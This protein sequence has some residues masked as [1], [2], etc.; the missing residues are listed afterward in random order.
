MRLNLLVTPRCWQHLTV[1]VCNNKQESLMQLQRLFSH[2]SVQNCFNLATFVRFSGTNNLR[3]CHNNSIGF[4]SELWIGHLDIILHDFVLESRIHGSISYGKQPRSQSNKAALRLPHSHQCL[5]VSLK[6]VLTYS[7]FYTRCNE[8]AHLCVV[9]FP[10]GFGQDI[11]WGANVRRPIFG[12][13]IKTQIKLYLYSPFQS[14]SNSKNNKVMQHKINN[15]ILNRLRFKG[16]S[17][18]TV[19]I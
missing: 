5:T 15:R 8:T 17:K 4:K 19:Q 10:K 7:Q 11:F 14:A 6:F 13:H 1:S 2:S 12:Q 16:D 9:C 3:S 18:Q